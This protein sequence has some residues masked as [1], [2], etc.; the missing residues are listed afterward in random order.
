MTNFKTLEWEVFLMK[1]ILKNLNRRFWNSEIFH[2]IETGDSY[3]IK[4]SPNKH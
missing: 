4:K 1:K 2:K 3:K